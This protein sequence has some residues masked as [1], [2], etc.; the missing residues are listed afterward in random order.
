MQEILRNI[1]ENVVKMRLTRWN[2]RERIGIPKTLLKLNRPNYPNNCL[3]LDLVRWNSSKVQQMK[4]LHFYF[5][6]GTEV[7][8]LIEDRQKTLKRL[9]KS[10]IF[11]TSGQELALEKISRPI[12]KYYAV[13]FHQNVF[14]E[15]DPSM[16]C[17][18]YPNENY[19][20]FDQCDTDFLKKT[21]STHFPPDFTPIWAVD[22]MENVTKWIFLDEKIFGKN[23]TIYDDLCEGR[24]SSNCPPPCTSTQIKIALVNEKYPFANISKIMIDFMPTLTRSKTDFPKFNAATFIS[25]LGGSMGFWLGLGVIQ[26][27]ELL[28]MLICRSTSTS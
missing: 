13:K 15:R 4:D 22:H 19:E 23:L 25:A 27:F 18:V 5:K 1:K 14:V 20:N 10:N 24:S 11:A 9:L 17:A 28:R 2:Q 12:M 6:N 16:S 7:S 26:T 3:T 21:L 8:I